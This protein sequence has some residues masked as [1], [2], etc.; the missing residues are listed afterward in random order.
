MWPKALF[1]GLR[2]HF[3]P[4]L[5]LPNCWGQQVP[6][7]HQVVGG[8]REGEDPPNLEHSPVPGLPQSSHCLEPSKYFFNAFPFLFADFITRV[9]RRPIIY[10]ASTPAPL[11]LRH[12][13]SHI[14][15]PHLFHKVLGV[16]SL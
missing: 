8:G 14:Q 11:I 13:R 12:V 1:S 15:V 3:S 6:H 9:T 16:I 10:C 4:D 5:C 7:P 2:T